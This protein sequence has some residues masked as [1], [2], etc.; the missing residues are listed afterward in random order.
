MKRKTM[1]AVAAMAVV[2]VAAVPVWSAP[3]EE[4]ADTSILPQVKPPPPPERP[5]LP[6]VP[7]RSSGSPPVNSF[8][9]PPIAPLP[10]PPSTNDATAAFKRDLLLPQIDNLRNQDSLGQL[11]PT[12]QRELLNKQQEL[13][14]LETDPLRH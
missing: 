2:G 14:Q 5:R 10:S 11:D 3:P 12:S 13:H 6:R 7:R 8:N 9:P 4:V 1:I